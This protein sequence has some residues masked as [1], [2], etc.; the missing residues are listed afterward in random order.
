M[1]SNSGETHG[2][3]LTNAV[4]EMGDKGDRKGKRNERFSKKGN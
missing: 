2:L 3:V 4:M 1:Q